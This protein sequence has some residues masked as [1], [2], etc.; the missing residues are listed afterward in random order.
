MSPVRTKHVSVDI[1]RLTQMVGTSELKVPWA[2]LALLISSSHMVYY[3]LCDSPSSSCFQISVQ[4]PKVHVLSWNFLWV[5]NMVSNEQ[6]RTIHYRTF[7]CPFVLGQKYFLVPLSLCPGTR[8]GVKIPEV[9]KQE[10]YIVKQK[11]M[12]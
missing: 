12:F 10:K 6:P 2:L 7:C 3:V 11:K 4:V 1:M 9:L 5:Q 8:A